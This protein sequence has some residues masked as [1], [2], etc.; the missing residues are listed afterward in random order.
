MTTT[1]PV[2]LGML[3]SAGEIRRVPTNG[4]LDQQRYAYVLWD[5]SPLAGSTWSREEAYMEL[6]RKYFGWIGPARLAHFQWFSGL[7]VGAAK[8][9]VEGLGLVPIEPGSD[10]LMLPDDL[11]EFA[12]FSPPKSPQVALVASIDGILLHRRDLAG[13]LDPADAQR[14]TMG[15]KGPRQVGGVQDLENHAIVDR[16]RLVGLWEYDPASSSIAWLS[17]SEHLD[18]VRD[19][20]GKMESFVRDQLG[21]ARSFSLDSPESRAPKI[22][23]IRAG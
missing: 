21:D 23:A 18:A 2:A 1:L 15:E 4:R 19:A 13:L 16:G 3:Q 9:A 5:E 7:G 14:E 6:A 17:W 11:D 20:V 10:L 8:A 12:A 22:A